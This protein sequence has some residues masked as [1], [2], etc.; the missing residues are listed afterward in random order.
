MKIYIITKTTSESS[1]LVSS[2]VE[3]VTLNKEK[4]IEKLEE[5][6]R[7]HYEENNQEEKH[8]HSTIMYLL[9]KFCI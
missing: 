1:S 2:G 5:L 3:L 7:K 8:I 9:T 6:K 4:A